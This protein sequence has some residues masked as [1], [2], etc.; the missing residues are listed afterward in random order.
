MPQSRNIKASASA[1]ARGRGADVAVR[2]HT[3]GL[4]AGEIAERPLS[5]RSIVASTLLGMRDPVLPAWLLVRCGALFGITEG[6]TRTALSRMVAAGELTP[7]GEGAYRLAGSLLDR[8]A[9][10]RESRQPAVRP[11]SGRWVHAVVVGER[12]SAAARAELRAAARILRLAELREGV[13]VRPDNLDVERHP[14]AAAVV[15]TQCQRW[16][17]RPVDE[18]PR[19]LAA[20]LWDLDAWTTRCDPLVDELE[21]WA[22]GIADRDESALAPSFLAGAALLRHLLADPLLPPELLPAEWPG[23]AVRD[24]YRTFETSFQAAYRDW[25]RSQR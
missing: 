14:A 9:R 10:Q 3:D 25:F 2:G 1:S 22:P 20:R 12:R 18:A 8:H 13:W 23:D 11:W 4:A 6:A 7:D 24:R 16:I 21:R 19:A 17:G 15:A 5:A